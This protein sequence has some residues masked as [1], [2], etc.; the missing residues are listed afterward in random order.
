MRYL[1]SIIFIALSL[2]FCLQSVYS[3]LRYFLVNY[4]IFGKKGLEEKYRLI[5]KDF[6]SFMSF[7]KEKIPSGAN[8]LFY[9]SWDECFQRYGK[10]AY[11]RFVYER[12]KSKFYLYPIK[13]YYL[14]F[15]DEVLGL[16]PY[17]E[18]E[19]LKKV[20]Y[21]ISLS[22]DRTF[23]GFKK[24]AEFTIDGMKKIILVKDDA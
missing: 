14:Y 4:P 20:D 7:C 11:Y 17:T 6:Y 10:D 21:I 2:F 9:N 3:D 16:N 22:V 18:E 15:K 13:V 5:D 23:A 12:Q 8:V 24:Y 19:V 1:I